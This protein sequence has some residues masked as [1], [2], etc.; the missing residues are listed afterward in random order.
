[1]DQP[2]PQVIAA[3]Q[4]GEHAAVAVL[5][6]WLNPDLLLFLRARDPASAEDI[7]S[8]TWI[9][10]GRSIRRFTGSEHDFRGWFFTIAWR[11]LIDWQ[12]K[13]SRRRST[14]A[15]DSIFDELTADADTADT[16]I[17]HLQTDAALQL[18]QSLPPEQA[19]VILLRVIAGLDAERVA[20]VMEKEIGNV[21]VLQHRGLRRLAVMLEHNAEADRVTP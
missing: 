8:E 12:R 18:L 3:A 7:A 19:E 15:D 4:A 9:R 11:A 14:P 1:V 17:E 21:R 13:E 2:F 20:R 16:A 6:K 10:A 5:W